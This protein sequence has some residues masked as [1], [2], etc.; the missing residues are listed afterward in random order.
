MRDRD[1]KCAACQERERL[2]SELY[3]KIRKRLQRQTTK[4]ND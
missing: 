1:C 3:L 4:Q 2:E